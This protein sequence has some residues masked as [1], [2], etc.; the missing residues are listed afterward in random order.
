MNEQQ[1]QGVFECLSSC[2]TDSYPDRITNICNKNCQY[3]NLQNVDKC[4]TPG[5]DQCKRVQKVIGQKANYQCQDRC[6]H[7]QFVNNKYECR[8]YVPLNMGQCGMMFKSGIWMPQTPCSINGQLDLAPYPVTNIIGFNKEISGT[9]ANYSVID[10]KQFGV[11]QNAVLVVNVS[12]EVQE[13]DANFSIFSNMDG[14][15]ENVTV[16]GYVNITYYNTK[17]NINISRLIGAVPASSDAE[18]STSDTRLFQNVTNNLKYYVNGNMITA[19]IIGTNKVKIVD[20]FNETAMPLPSTLIT[21]ETYQLSNNVGLVKTEYVFH[22]HAP[23]EE[24]IVFIYSDKSLAGLV[25]QK[26]YLLSFTKFLEAA[27]V[28]KGKTSM[29]FD[30]NGQQITTGTI[31]VVV[32]YDD[33]TAL[34]I[35]VDAI[36]TVRCDNLDIYNPETKQCTDFKT[37]L[38]KQNKFVYKSLCLPACILPHSNVDGICYIECPVHLGYKSLNG[39]CTKSSCTSPQFQTPISCGSTCDAT[40][41]TL[42]IRKLENGIKIDTD[43]GCVKDCPKGT[44][45]LASPNRC[46]IP[47]A[48][49][50][51]LNGDLFIQVLKIEAHQTD[52]RYHNQCLSSAPSSTFNTVST[53]TYSNWKTANNQLLSLN[54]IFTI[55]QTC[56]TVV[57]SFTNQMKPLLFGTECRLICPTGQFDQLDGTCSPSCPLEFMAEDREFGTCAYCLPNEFFDAYNK[58]CLSSSKYFKTVEGHNISIT[59]EEALNTQSELEGCKHYK[60]SDNLIQCVYSCAELKLVQGPGYECITKCPAK[61][62]IG[63]FNATCSTQCGT[64]PATQYYKVEQLNGTETI[65]NNDPKYTSIK[66]YND[67]S[68]CLTNLVDDQTTFAANKRCLGCP[69]GTVWNRSSSV[70]IPEK[71]CTFFDT[72]PAPKICESLTDLVNCKTYNS[73]GETGI[74]ICSSQGCG[75]NTYS[76]NQFCVRS[77]IRYQKFTSIIDYN[78]GTVDRNCIEQ[79]TPNYFNIQGTENVCLPTCTGKYAPTSKGLC[80]CA[81]TPIKYYYINDD[82]QEKCEG[83][84]KYD[85]IN[86]ECNNICYYQVDQITGRQ[87]CNQIK[88]SC[89]NML[90]NGKQCVGACSANQFIDVRECVAKCPTLMYFEYNNNNTCVSDFKSCPFFLR[91]GDQKK[92]FAACPADKPY[93]FNQECV[94]NCSSVDMKTSGMTCVSSCSGVRSFFENKQCVESCSS[95]TYFNDTK[96]CVTSLAECNVYIQDQTDSK[97]CLK[98]C[99]LA[100]PFINNQMCVAQCDK[101]FLNWNMTC[102]ETNVSCDMI[103]LQ[104]PGK[105]VFN[106]TKTCNF[107]VS[108]VINGKYQFQCFKKC[109]DYKDAKN[110]TLSYFIQTY[111]GGKCIKTCTDEIS[112]TEPMVYV[113]VSDQFSYNQCVVSCSE[114]TT[115]LKVFKEDGFPYNY[116]VHKCQENS[117][118]DTTK[119]QC[120]KS[121]CPSSTPYYFIDSMKNKLC[122]TNC[123][124]SYVILN[125]AQCLVKC[126]ENF[127]ALNSN[128]VAINKTTQTAMYIVVGAIMV[129]MALTILIMDHI[130]KKKLAAA[131]LKRKKGKKSKE[132]E[133]GQTKKPQIKINL[134]NQL[135]APLN[136]NNAQSYTSGIKPLLRQIQEQNNKAELPKKIKKPVIRVETNSASNQKMKMVHKHSHGIL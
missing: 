67:L 106:C 74:F 45:E 103:D 112:G 85:D 32:Y 38:E 79:C 11:L 57:N 14:R 49:T 88:S 36:E 110:Q 124:K 100:T 126:P 76:N 102:V 116:C 135:S 101:G 83:E 70:C 10:I 44:I 28:I 62:A 40:F 3:L 50:D 130:N 56:D 82:C 60:W 132:I 22:N 136:T 24:F 134:S 118:V 128:C 131:R 64:N 2:P 96:L 105:G 29:Y 6:S 12:I 17:P 41:K 54:N 20:L 21:P 35:P 26:H 84:Y 89:E 65:N 33:Y 95:K 119:Q 123:P 125:Q 31:A 47:G 115:Q 52:P 9:S 43:V 98:T 121:D 59:E 120:Q 63:T 7:N 19:D 92:C 42:S 27:F 53:K 16:I 72:Y 73:S 80:K 113:Y 8:D 122:F 1:T 15:L 58:R 4:E 99:P 37:C 34:A 5:S 91:V 68:T 87:S 127:K 108:T 111:R 90:S 69:V 114:I 78:N 13:T 81:E 30:A 71:N 66:C 77:C 18:S 86:Q 51:C 23:T 75:N 97:A 61:Q 129:I 107:Y 94:V 46:L 55:Q 25:Y 133:L 104:I 93:S 117:T 39:G 48:E 109:N